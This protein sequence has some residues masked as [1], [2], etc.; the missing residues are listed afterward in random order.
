MMLEDAGSPLVVTESWLSERLPS[1]PALVICLDT[2][3]EAMSRQS[4]HRLN[5]CGVADNLAYVMYTYG[6]TGRQKGISIIQRAVVRLVK[7]VD[8]VCAT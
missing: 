1:V 6:T 5:V 7:G 8:Y 2:I 4:R 3:E